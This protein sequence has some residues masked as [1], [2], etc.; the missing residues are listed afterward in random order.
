MLSFN[1]F[2][3][4]QLYRVVVVWVKIALLGRG[5]LRHLSALPFYLSA[6][7]RSVIISP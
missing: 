4:K 3:M 2:D 5:I 7:V 1:E 6:S